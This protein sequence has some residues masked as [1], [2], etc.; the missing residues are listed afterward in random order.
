VDHPT[1]AIEWFQIIMLAVPIAMVALL[2]HKTRK[3]HLATYH[4]VSDAAR[5]RKET[6]ALFS[7][8]QALLALERKLSLPE[9]LPA[10]RGWA[11]SPDFLLRIA[12]EI[13]ERKPKVVM[14]CS[15]GVSTLVVARCLQIN[16]KGRVFSLEHD[17]QYAGATR[18]L[19]DKHGLAEWAT[20]LDAP[21]VTVH[22]K[23]P[24]YREESI[25]RDLEPIDVLI[26][27]GPPEA[28]APL[29]R[30]P[31]L[32]RLSSRL[33]NTALIIL[34]DANRDDETEIVKRWL[35]MFPMLRYTDGGCEKGCALL[36]YRIQPL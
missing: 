27:D 3:I 32:P 36:E 9:A 30:F 19:L 15:S 13:R 2:L 10:M 33:A 8:I 5:T 1:I 4:L 23:T 14:E 20:V 6:E 28:V 7:Q 21:L 31:A 11:G 12:D 17:P 22:T 24:W 26:V 35:Q 16:G 25:P 29:A 18:K 34:D